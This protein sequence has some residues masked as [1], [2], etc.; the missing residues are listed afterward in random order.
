MQNNAFFLI[1]IV[2][3]R[4]V[5][6][7]TMLCWTNY[8]LWATAEENRMQNQIVQVDTLVSS[9]ILQDIYN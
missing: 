7:G 5:N 3:K 6:A 4:N 9:T 1:L 2:K 8:D